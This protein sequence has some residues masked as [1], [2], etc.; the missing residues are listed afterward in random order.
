MTSHTESITTAAVGQAAVA[1]PIV[2]R[3]PFFYG[4][5][6]LPVAMAAHVATSPGQ[7]FGISVFNSALRESLALSQSQLA[8]AYLFGT[9]LAS[10]PV[11]LVGAAMDRFG[12]RRTIITVVTCLGL[13]CFFTASVQGL[14]SLFF[15]FLLLRTIGQGALTLVASNTLAMWFHDRLGTVMGMTSMAMAAA[16]A[17]VPPLLL[18]GMET[19]GWRA[20]YAACGLAVWALLPVLVALYR[21]R[22][23]DIGQ[24]PDGRCP[25][26]HAPEAHHP[27][28]APPSTPSHPSPSTTHPPPA[29]TSAATPAATS[30]TTPAAPLPATAP[31]TPTTP[32]AATPPISNTTTT[33]AAPTIDFDLEA[34]FR[35]RSYW[36]LLSTNAVWALIA[37]AIVF[38]IVPFCESVGLSRATAAATFTTF[39]VAMAGMQLL[40]GY[41]A[42]RLPLNALLAC[43]VAGLAVG[44]VVLLH[45]SRPWHAHVYAAIF[46]T[47]QGLVGVSSNTAWARYFGRAHLGKIRGSTWTAAVAGSSIGPLVMGLAYDHFGSYRPALWLFAAMF[48]PL[49]L[50]VLW[51]TPPRRP[52]TAR[53]A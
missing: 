1:D 30:A 23:E 21:N 51:A 19:L 16:I 52:A 8:G 37:T 6:M 32:V 29:T 10:L 18:R 45:V 28:H 33:A 53:D 26:H 2:R 4:W 24:L 14:V 49:V 36:I 17:V 38:H 25:S 34:A 11:S 47:S 31:S 7:T 41:L 43:G 15:A 9:L 48:A 44:V 22:P 27:R 12:M 35:T 20:T 3:F 50:A 39:A 46:G 5:V 42:D 13:A 40:G